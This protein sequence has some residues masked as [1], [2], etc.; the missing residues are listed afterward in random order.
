MST[1]HTPLICDYATG[2]G[3]AQLYCCFRDCVAPAVADVGYAISEEWS[4]WVAVC[5]EHREQL[6]VFV[7]ERFDPEPST[8]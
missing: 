5:A 8:P 2:D 3:D 7:Y 6:N 1:H 4:C